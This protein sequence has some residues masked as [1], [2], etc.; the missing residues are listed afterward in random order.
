M[1]A[2]CVRQEDDTDS[3]VQEHSSFSVAHTKLTASCVGK[4][5]N[6]LM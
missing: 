6:D 3:A 4:I 5:K 1:N 2:L